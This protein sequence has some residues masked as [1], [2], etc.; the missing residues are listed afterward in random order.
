MLESVEERVT[1]WG[2]SVTNADL[3]PLVARIDYLAQNLYSDYEPSARPGPDFWSRC[4]RWLDSAPSEEDQKLLLQLIPY[5]FFVGVS[6]FRAYYRAALNINVVQWISDL[7]GLDPEDPTGR[8][9]LNDE[10]GR[11]WFCGITD[12]MQIAAFYH[13]NGLSGR[14]YRPDWRSLQKF[15]D[16]AKIDTYMVQNQISRIV[17][18]EDFVGSGSQMA[19]SARF[20]A[21][22]PSRPPILLIPLVIC[23][24]GCEK[25]AE[26]R[27]QFY[28]LTFSP[29]IALGEEA[30]LTGVPLPD[31][32]EIYTQVRDLVLRLEH[33][34][35]NGG[36]ETYYGP[37]GFP[38]PDGTGALVVLNT[39][40]PDNTLPLLHRTSDEWSP[41]FPRSSRV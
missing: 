40:C 2:S 24:E 6:Q 31:E 27:A 38:A 35:K 14:D 37:W 3:L 20:A 5:I 33:L 36:A 29:V 11:T 22:L 18:L 26:L 17:L 19:N 12:S 9:Q 25:G 8:D 15:A 41:L 13:V 16:P 10:I 1:R 21:Q 30:M 32:P 28:N 7:I 34:I 39:N 23:P 4:A